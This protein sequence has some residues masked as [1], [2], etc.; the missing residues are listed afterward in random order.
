MNGSPLVTVGI[1]T[2]NRASALTRALESVLAQDYTN[3]EVVISDNASTDDTCPK[4]SGLDPR[5]QTAGENLGQ[6]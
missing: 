4:L 3:L 6:R 1:P 5:I 2:Y